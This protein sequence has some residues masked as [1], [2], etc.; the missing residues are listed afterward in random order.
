MSL[1]EVWKEYRSYIILVS[2][3]TL[4]SFASVFG[5]TMYKREEKDK[6]KAYRDSVAKISSMEKFRID[7]LPILNSMEK[8]KY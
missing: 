1:T 7:V 4:A 5:Y 6:E 3:A 8:E 2:F